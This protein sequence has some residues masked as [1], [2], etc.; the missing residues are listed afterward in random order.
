[1][2]GLG[3]V[4]H[5]CS[6]LL[7]STT[8]TSIH[9]IRRPRLNWLSVTDACSFSLKWSSSVVL[10]VVYTYFANLCYRYAI[11]GIE[12]QMSKVIWQKVAFVRRCAVDRHI[13]QRRQAN[14]VECTHAYLRYNWAV[15]VSL[16][17]VSLKGAPT[18]PVGKFRAPSN[19]WFLG[20]TQVFPLCV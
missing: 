20:L 10:T 7:Y 15:H 11:A 12:E 18:R 13:R 9:R 17:H 8:P 16:L 2:L 5:F 19:T 4:A 1:M 6:R 14:N 3:L